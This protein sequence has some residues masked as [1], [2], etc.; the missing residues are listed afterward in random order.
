MAKGLSLDEIKKSGYL[1][2]PDPVSEKVMENNPDIKAKQYEML[3]LLK[4][5]Y[6]Q[7]LYDQ[8]VR[9]DLGE[10]LKN[11]ELE[12]LKSGLLRLG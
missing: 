2:N 8:G 7:R 6:R 5:A 9:E 1:I 3:K 10:M 4:D 11:Q 12:M